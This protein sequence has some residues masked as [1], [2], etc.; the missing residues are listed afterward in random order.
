MNYYDLSYAMG[1]QDYE[2]VDALL[3]KG[4][5]INEQKPEYLNCLS[6]DLIKVF[7]KHGVDLNGCDAATKTTLLHRLAWADLPEVFDFAY[8]NGCTRWTKDR[9]WR[10]PYI[11]AQEGRREKMLHHLITYYPD[12]IT[13]KIEPVDTETYSFERVHCFKQSVLNPDWFFGLTNNGILIRYRVE[14]TELLVDKI[15]DLNVPLIRNFTFDKNENIIIPN[16]DRKLLIVDQENI[17]LIN[18]IDLGDELI[19]D[20]IEYLPLK[21]VYIGSSHR[22]RITVLGED[23]KILSTVSAY[24]GTIDPMINRHENLIAFLSYNQESYYCLYELNDKLEIK[25]IYK[26]IKYYD[27]PSSGF[28]FNDNRFAVS[29]PLVFEFFR[30]VNGRVKKQWNIDI[31]QIQ[32]E[33][34]LSSLAFINSNEIVLGKGKTLFYIDKKER[35]IVREEKVDLQAEI[36]D[37]FPD[38]NKEN[39]IISTDAELKLFPLGNRK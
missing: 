29:F 27:N 23:F 13:N 37:L 2:A 3:S 9:S 31:S 28:A 5:K 10:T 22:W 12:L 33:Y 20:Q 6:I 32:S 39:L 35:K 34:H 1:Q 17:Q 25:F 4:V 14:N 7:L 11:L 19:L 38:N 24:S 21:N 30:F 26:F 8:N 15:V 16:G 18:T 36:K